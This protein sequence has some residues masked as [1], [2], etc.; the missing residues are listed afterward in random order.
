M[1]LKDLF[2]NKAEQVVIDKSLES[3]ASEVQ[4]DKYIDNIIEDNNRYLPVVDFSSPANFARY[5]S[6]EKYYVDGIKNIYQHYPYDGSKKEK[7]EWRNNSSQID[8]YIFD[9]IYPKT[10]GYINLSSSTNLLNSS[11]FRYT[12]QPTYIAIKG[13]PNASDTGRLSDSNIYDPDFNRESNFSLTNNGNTV[14][15]WLKDEVTNTNSNYAYAY[16]IFDLWNGITA[17]ANNYTRLSILKA[18]GSNKLEVTYRSGSY[19]IT[20]ELIDYTLD[21]ST[22]HHYAISFANTNTTDLQVSLYVDGELVKQ[23]IHVGTGIINVTDNANSIAYI[24]SLRTHPVTTN[25][26]YSTYGSAY[27]SIDEFRFWKAERTTQEIYRNWF[28]QVGGGSN[29][30]DANTSLGVYLKFNEGIINTVEINDLDKVCLDYSGRIS[31][32]TINNYYLG[33]KLTG[34]AVDVYFGETKETKD[35]IIFSTNALIQTALN[36]YGDLGFQYDQTNVSSIYKSLPAWITEEAEKLQLG[37]LSNLIQII[38]SYFDILHIQIENISK[39]KNLDYS[40]NSEKPKPFANILLSSHDFDNLEL[41][42]DTTLIEKV[43]SRSES[44]EFEQNINDIKNSIYQNIYNNLVYIYK[45]KGTEKA[46]RN[47]IRCFGVD[48]ELIK[49]NLYSNNTTYDISEKYTYSSKPKKFVDFNNPDRYDGYIYQKRKASDTTN[50]LSYIPSANDGKLDFV[51]ITVQSEIIFPKQL[52]I[53]SDNYFTVNFVSSSLFGVH[54]AN[55]DQ[56]IYSWGSDTF[57]FQVYSVRAKAGSPD[58]YFKLTGSFNG[59]PVSLTSN[60]YKEL[61][62][63]EKWNFA[64]RIKPSKFNHANF[65]SGSQITDYDLEFIGYNSVS[66]QIYN[67]FALSATVAQANMTPALRVNK[68]VYVGAHYNNFNSS[69]LLEKTDVKASSVR[70]WYDYLTNEELLA[71][72]YESDNFGRQ[73]PNWHPDY[74][75]SLTSSRSFT[76]AD[77]LLLHWDFATVT[78]SDNNGQFVVEDISSGSYLDTQ[79]YGLSWFG[80]YAKYQYPGFA[81]EFLEN[82]DQVVNKEFILSAKKQSFE[83]LNGDDLVQTPDVDDITRTKDSRLVSYFLSIE[84]SMAQVVNDEILKWF[85]T[86]KNFNNLIG[87]PAERYNREYSGMR[88]MREIFFKN[89]NNRLDFEKFFEFYKWIDS[90]LSNVV[91]QLIPASA[92]SSA[93]IRNIIESHVLERNKYENKLPTIEFKGEPKS[94]PIVSHLNY[95]YRE[96]AAYPNNLTT[97]ENPTRYYNF[98]PLWLKQRVQRSDSIVDTDLEPQNDIDREIIRQVINQKNID[99][100][101]TLFS[102][103]NAYEGR[104][105]ITRNFTKTYNFSTKNLYVLEDTINPLNISNNLFNS[106]FV[107]AAEIAASSSEQQIIQPIKKKG[108]YSRVYEYLFTSGRTGNNKSF[109]DLEGDVQ[110]TTGSTLFVFSDRSLPVRRAYKNIIVER[111]SA[112]GGPEINGRGFL[113][114][115]AEEYSVYNSLNYRNSRVRNNYNS[116]LRETSSI[117]PDYPSYHKVTKNATYI[118]ID[119]TSSQV[120]PYYDNWFVSHAIPRSDLQYAWITASVTGSD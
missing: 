25:N 56:D 3:I 29:T 23:D 1:S 49:I 13:G 58:A 22:W 110:G 103:G 105:D 118:P 40:T 85:A 66:N 89:V 42:T 24:G 52:E 109:V 38:S 97:E 37:D 34:S 27:V 94:Y 101:P 17:S 28:T 30:D 9:N 54:E 16:S 55:V 20:T 70:F 93:D 72:S 26:S 83:N 111:F 60:L 82:D 5:G 43:F 86:I 62:N 90:S 104:K 51:P 11:G 57:N 71:H 107:F 108:N 98:K 41:F 65:A 87:N 53:E 63:N 64:V 99:K 67:S 33:C 78:S 113:D 106:T 44:S 14:E 88:Q 81:D 92:N 19:G 36:A 75:L 114:S 119:V 32:G 6:A 47:L 50:T 10:T 68:R 59:S 95:N 31:N 102:D 45:S 84:K 46:L 112:P 48:D 18:S 115:A 120:E 12:T 61:Y 7:L 15:F 80:Q 117:D 96:Q 76:K 8:L 35:P 69:S 77:T 116:W 4:S 74:F 2:N 73:Q 91:S 39:I 100:L 79:E 21:T